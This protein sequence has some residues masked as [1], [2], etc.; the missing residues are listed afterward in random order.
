MFCSNCGD[1][2]PKG[3]VFC[4]KCGKQLKVQTKT[5]GMHVNAEA[6]EPLKVP[7]RSRGDGKA[8][9]NPKALGIA[10]VVA[11]LLVGMA[12]SM[13]A[14]SGNKA[15]V[16][17][18]REASSQ[19]AEPPGISKDS[20]FL[21]EW[22]LVELSIGDQVTENFQPNTVE[23]RQDGTVVWVD[24]GK[25]TQGTWEESGSTASMEIGDRSFT[26]SNYENKYLYAEY[27]DM[28]LM[29]VPIGSFA[30]RWKAV[31]GSLGDIGEEDLAA[32]NAAGGK[33]ILKLNKDNTGEFLITGPGMDGD[34]MQEDFTWESSSDE[35]AT[36]LDFDGDD[37]IMKLSNDQLTMSDKS[38]S[39]KLIFERF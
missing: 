27:G 20:F 39:Q 38:G 16:E 36:M 28:L 9:A 37:A 6:K 33:L 15:P 30:G 13:F 12:L 17:G 5:P 24:S 10:A 4:E 2:L 19:A 11:A 14:C 3:A 35:E 22:G 7:T 32:F 1:E 8:L 26:L 25:T 29:Y 21:G 31:D 23:L 18:E 34:E